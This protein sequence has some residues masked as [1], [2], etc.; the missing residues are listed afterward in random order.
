MQVEADWSEPLDLQV[1]LGLQ[2]TLGPSLALW[3]TS[4]LESL[5]TYNVSLCFPP[6]ITLL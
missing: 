5:H 2:D 6:D 1:H 4:P 3:M